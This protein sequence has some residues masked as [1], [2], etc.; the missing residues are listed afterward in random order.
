MSSFL[1][2]QFAHKHFCLVRK[3]ASQNNSEGGLHDDKDGVVLTK[4]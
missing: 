2:M 4:I 3:I 1:C